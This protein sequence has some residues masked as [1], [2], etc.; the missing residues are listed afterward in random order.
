VDYPITDA[1]VDAEGNN[2]YV[3]CAGS[4]TLVVS[5]KTYINDNWVEDAEADSEWEVV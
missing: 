5:M 2:R 3:Q 1:N 4:E